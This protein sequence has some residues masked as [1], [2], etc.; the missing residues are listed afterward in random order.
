M[1]QAG[2]P[3]AAASVAAP[4]LRLWATVLCCLLWGQARGLQ[5]VLQNLSKSEAGKEFTRV[6]GEEGE[7]RTVLGSAE[8]VLL[9][10]DQVCD[11]VCGCEGSAAGPIWVC[12]GHFDLLRSWLCSG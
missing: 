10:S 12:L 11:G 6:Q 5:E 7:R 4:I 3:A 8:K 9:G 2:S 1:S